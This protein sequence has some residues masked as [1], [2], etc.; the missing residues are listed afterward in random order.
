MS[1]DGL[2]RIVASI[3]PAMVVVTTAVPGE[4]AGCLV[5]FHS[6]SA[7]D[8]ARYAIWLS[9]ANHTYRVGLRAS[10]FAV[11]FLTV[12]DLRL[13]ELFGT[14][15]GDDGDKFADLD[16]ADGPGGVPLLRA[17]ANR[18]VARRVALLDEGGDHVCV[19]T[20]VEESGSDAP[21]E[22]LRLSAVEHLTPGHESEERNLPPT[23]RAAD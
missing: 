21:F 5:G 1:A 20:E 17:C 4:R 22:P 19:T 14:R 3:D 6:Q 18:L 12:D 2:D 11:H 7:I 23:E 9:K 15:T 16:V 10:H 8:P 13:A